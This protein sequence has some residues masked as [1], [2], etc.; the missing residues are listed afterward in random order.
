M[1]TTVTILEDHFKSLKEILFENPSFGKPAILLCGRSTIST[2]VWGDGKEERYLSRELFPLPLKN[3]GTKP[4]NDLQSDVVAGYE[5]LKKAL[6]DN[7]AIAFVSGIRGEG[8]PLFFEE[9]REKEFFGELFNNIEGNGNLLSLKI[10]ENGEITGKAWAPDL[11]STEVNF[12]RVIGKRFSFYYPEKYELVPREEFHRQQ[13]AF[14]PTINSDFSKLKVGIIGCGATGSATAHLLTRLGVGQL[15]L[16]D[17]DHV[18]RTNL[19]RLYGA[20]LNDVGK[21]KVEVLKD[22]LVNIGLGTRIISIHNWVGTAQCRD[23][24][25]SCD[26]IFGCTDDNTG[27]IFLNRLAFFYYI[28]VFDMGVDIDPSLTEPGRLQTLQGRV[29]VVTPGVT[30]LIC[31]NV[32]DMEKARNESIKRTDPIRYEKLVVND[33]YVK[34][35]NNPSPAVITFTTEVA[36]MA[37]N[38]F[39]NRLTGFKQ[40]RAENSIMRFFDKSTDQKPGSNPQEYCPVCSNAKLWGLGDIQPFMDMIS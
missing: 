15:L 7:L 17:N 14:G 37:L 21:S 28:P 23:Y 16:I 13:L 4:Q 31:R 20:T 39:I 32:I 35:E 36:T 2:D 22:F 27:R 12:I 10:S 40:G 25:K 5:I 6:I 29:T 33:G 11:T 3:S 19:N 34:R 26:V 8:S 30:C 1:I 24:L 38:E 18:E 9:G